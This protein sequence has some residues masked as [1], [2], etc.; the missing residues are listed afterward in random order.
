MIM[1]SVAETVRA[2]PTQR[3]SAGR[4]G[5]FTTQ[6]LSKRAAR[7]RRRRAASKCPLLQLK[8][9]AITSTTVVL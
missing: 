7:R 6:A 8:K 9:L 4:S 5:I 2:M 1:A 3:F